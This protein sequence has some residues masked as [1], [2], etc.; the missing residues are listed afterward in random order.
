MHHSGLE[1]DLRVDLHLLKGVDTWMSL[2]TDDA[3]VPGFFYR[4]HHKN[5]PELRA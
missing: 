3:L 2:E 1:S 4:C 5:F